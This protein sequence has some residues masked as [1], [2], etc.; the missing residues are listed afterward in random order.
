MPKKAITF[1]VGIILKARRI[2]LLVWDECKADIL[3]QAVEG[4]VTEFCFC[5]LL[6]GPMLHCITNLSWLNMQPWKH[7]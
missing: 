4:T 6:A 5:F 2:I 1:S 7:K 3:K